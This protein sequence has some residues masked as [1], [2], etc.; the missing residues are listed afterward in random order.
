MKKALLFLL[1]ASLTPVVASA[2]ELVTYVPAPMRLYSTQA[3]MKKMMAEQPNDA[4]TILAQE[5]WSYDYRYYG[6]PD[7]VTIPVV[8][9]VFTNAEGQPLVNTED[10]QTQ[11]ARLNID[12]FTPEHP[13]TKQEGAGDT[14]LHLADQK[15]G[16][17][18]HAANTMIQF[19]QPRVDPT[20]NETNGIIMVSGASAAF[21]IDNTIKAG[22]TGGSTPWETKSY[23]NVW[24]ADLG[25]QTAG[26]A[27]MPGISP[28]TDGIVIDYRYFARAAG[29][30]KPDGFVGEFGLGRTLVHLMGSYLNLHELWNEAQPCSDDYV[31]DTPIHNAPNHGRG[32][33]KHVSTCEG[34]LVEMT[35]NLMDSGNDSTMYLFTWGQMMRMQAVLAEGGARHDLTLT[36]LP[37]TKE[38]GGFSD[39]GQERE[40]TETLT[41][42]MPFQ[43]RVLP[44]PS[45]GQFTLEINCGTPLTEAFQTFLYD[46]LG[47]L[48]WQQSINGAGQTVRHAFNGHPLPPGVYALKAVNGK[49]VSTV[50]VLVR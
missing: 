35:T 40:Q 4:E 25:G 42:T 46:E 49:Q 38:N 45:N 39:D 36:E 31:E 30:V 5:R 15:E 13:Y 7:T 1:F 28:A 12:F 11:I 10:I 24:V 22:E 21:E 26:F 17:A 44:N 9:H 6:T 27:Q 23:C 16:F 29:S 37:C 8:F 3:Y 32:D 47:H 19:C 43:L 48:V 50:Q 33:Y 41:E 14:Y 18:R 20:G 2:Q 34:N